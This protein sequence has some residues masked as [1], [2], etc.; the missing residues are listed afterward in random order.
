MVSL[1]ALPTTYIPYTPA[2]HA[3]ILFCPTT[4]W[5][6]PRLLP[7]LPSPSTSPLSLPLPS[8]SSTPYVPHSVVL[9]PFPPFPCLPPPYLYEQYVTLL[10][11]SSN[12]SVHFSWHGVTWAGHTF[13][14]L[15]VETGQ[16]TGMSD[17][18]LPRRAFIPPPPPTLPARHCHYDHVIFVLFLH[19]WA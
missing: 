14:A 3:T 10:G 9:V 12:N 6:A 16:K 5:H 18:R 15:G 19:C 7:F 11:I 2:C 8:T 4:H 1:H 13:C 17:V